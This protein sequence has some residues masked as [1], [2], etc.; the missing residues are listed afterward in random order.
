MR[1]CSFRVIAFSL[2]LVSAVFA[3][4]GNRQDNEEKEEIRVVSKPI[5]S[6]VVYEFSRTVGPGRIIKSKEGVDGALIQTY[7]V[8]FKDGK[9]FKKELVREER[10]EPTPTLMLMGRTK[11]TPSRSS[12]SRKRVVDMVATAYDP[13]PRTI[14]PGATGRTRTGCRAT[15]GCIAVDP[16]VIPL[17]TH[18]YVEGYGYGTACDTGSAIKGNKIDLCYDS[19]SV[20]LRFGRKKMRVHILGK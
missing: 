18:L 7:R 2:M 13:S 17:G 12:F 10:K 15:H 5:P 3:F 9:P 19:R 14:G 8:S 1:N 11:K 4:G 16:R 20:A 6:K